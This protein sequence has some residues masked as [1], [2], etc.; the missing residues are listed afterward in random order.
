MR[1]H[2]LPRRRAA[3]VLGVLLILLGT[4]AG[5]IAGREIASLAN[6]PAEVRAAS[7]PTNR[8]F[9]GFGVTWLNAVAYTTDPVS[10]GTL[11]TAAAIVPTPPQ[12][13]RLVDCGLVPWPKSASCTTA[14][15]GTGSSGS[16]AKACQLWKADLATLRALH[17]AY[18]R[19]VMALPWFATCNA[20]GKLQLSWNSPLW[21]QKVQVLETLKS[22]R[23]PVILTVSPTPDALRAPMG[24]GSS[25]AC[26]AYP[27]PS[28][29]PHTRWTTAIDA[30]L[31]HVVVVDKLTNIRY[32]GAV[33]EPNGAG[34]LVPISTGEHP[35][36]A[37]R[38]LEKDPITF[39]D[40]EDATS[41]IASYLASNPMLNGHAGV[42]DV[43]V[44]GPSLS[45]PSGNADSSLAWACG[46]LP[47]SVQ[48]T[49]PKQDTAVNAC[50]P[51]AASSL[52]AHEPGFGGYDWH[53]YIPPSPSVPASDCAANDSR[54][55]TEG[56]GYDEL[57]RM[58]I[59][60]ATQFEGM[61]TDATDL[62]AEGHG[63][64]VFMTELGVRDFGRTAD[65]K[66]VVDYGGRGITTNAYAVAMFDYGLHVLSAHVDAALAW[67]LDNDVV[68]STVPGAGM[69][70]DDAPP[71]RSA[72][73]EPWFQTW[74]M[75]TRAFPPG[76][77]IYNLQQLP[78]G[79]DG[80]M[81]SANAPCD[82]GHV[83]TYAFTDMNMLASPTAAPTTDQSISLIVPA[84]S[85]YVVCQ[86]NGSAQAPSTW[87]V[88]DSGSSTRSTSL[89]VQLDRSSSTVVQFQPAGSAPTACP[90]A[91]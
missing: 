68:D 75:L 41:A 54:T 56:E 5:V 11:C 81:G 91:R 58:K 36:K 19:T 8:D 83:Q 71:G 15:A 39:L 14:T 18:V 67:S 4:A 43:K 25:Q 77:A 38:L 3:P 35:T 10:D 37:E 6:S 65:G 48:A 84:N 28:K 17:P 26:L 29:T 85:R 27:D 69:V 50:W 62:A 49:Q 66:C 80:V 13:P 32:F 59:P 51:Q 72:A 7:T 30:L 63:L 22:L 40:W 2:H 78:A 9:L 70:S 16:A 1:H 52:A 60:D 44:I 31:E 90:A 21:R 23:I 76:S 73:I 55:A 46:H 12:H 34:L 89:E 20:A 24:G 87:Q 88:T 64:P 33:S 74:R 61:A 57:A 86:F 47:P 53:Q 45:N 42:G 82:C 79:V